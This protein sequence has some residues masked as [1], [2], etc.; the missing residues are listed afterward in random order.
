[1]FRNNRQPRISM[2]HAVAVSPSPAA[3]PVENTGTGGAGM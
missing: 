3:V 2:Q 1:M